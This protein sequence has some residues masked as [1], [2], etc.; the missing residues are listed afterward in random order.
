MAE[1]EKKNSI[2]VTK[3]RERVDKNGNTYLIGSLGMATMML[4]RHKTNHD[5]WNMMLMENNKK[6]QAPRGG[7]FSGYQFSEDEIPF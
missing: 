5:E 4:R 3:L 7:G 1:N 2:F 6:D